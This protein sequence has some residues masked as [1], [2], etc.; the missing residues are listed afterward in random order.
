MRPSLL[1]P[2]M[3][4]VKMQKGQNV[5]RT[6]AIIVTLLHFLIIT[7][8][9]SSYFQLLIYYLIYSLACVN[10]SKIDVH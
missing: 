6:E 8:F 2:N 10:M 9:H 5:K 1:S 4:N 7:L 3:E